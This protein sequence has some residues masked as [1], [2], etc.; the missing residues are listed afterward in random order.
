M[1]YIP[2]ISRS[3]F[4]Y[5]YH[6]HN[7]IIPIMWKKTTLAYHTKVPYF[8]ITSLH[9]R[10]IGSIF[11]AITNFRAT[12]NSQQEVIPVLPDISYGFEYI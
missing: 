6:I 11:Q 4:Y 2:I 12:V 8:S 9:L 5:N 3:K 7:P 10:S 1:Y